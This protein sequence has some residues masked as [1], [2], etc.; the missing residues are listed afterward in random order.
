[1]LALWVF[2]SADLLPEKIRTVKIIFSITGFEDF[3]GP[4]IY[5]DNGNTSLLFELQGS[6]LIDNR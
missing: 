3:G 2:P 4:V 6:I 5:H 1:M